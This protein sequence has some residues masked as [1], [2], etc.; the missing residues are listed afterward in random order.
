MSPCMRRPAR[1]IDGT[2]AG[3]N[4]VL[5]ALIVLY[6]VARVSQLFAGMVP[7]LPIVVMH[8]IPPALFALI[9]GGRLYGFRG[10]LTFVALCLV[11]GNLFENLGVLTGVPFGRYYFTAVMGPSLLH[12]PILLGLAYSG[13]TGHQN[14]DVVR[15]R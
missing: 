6:A 3:T 2:A 11:V 12:V 8:V 4:R 13:C 9:H 1:S 10:I 15:V 5:W 14:S 7:M